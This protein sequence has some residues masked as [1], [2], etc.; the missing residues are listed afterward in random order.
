MEDVIYTGLNAGEQYQVKY[1][2]SNHVNYGKT[3]IMEW[4]GITFRDTNNE[5]H[6]LGI[7]APVR[8]AH[9]DEMIVIPKTI[10]RETRLRRF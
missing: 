10:R 3:E 5:Q 8:H 4:R 1:T 6:Y 9:K 7:V 2:N